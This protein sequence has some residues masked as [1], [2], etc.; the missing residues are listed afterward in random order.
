[1]WASTPN[2]ILE[3]IDFRDAH[4]NYQI[5]SINEYNF[6][7][8]YIIYACNVKHLLS[9]SNL[10]NVCI[11]SISMGISLIRLSPKNI[12]Q[13]VVDLANVVGISV[14]RFF[15]IC[16]DSSD[17]ILW[18]SASHPASP[19]KNKNKRHFSIESISSF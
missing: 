3:A 9:T 6:D 18:K 10:V 4:N 16:K 8:K 7:A 14:R 11:E 13:I 1:M 19:P 12:S 15:A 17:F 2:S 5:G